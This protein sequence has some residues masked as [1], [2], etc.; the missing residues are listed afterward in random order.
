MISLLGA[1]NGLGLRGGCLGG[2]GT[3][4]TGLGGHGKTLLDDE[5]VTLAREKS[6]A[7]RVCSRNLREHKR[8]PEDRHVL[9]LPR[10]GPLYGGCDC[11][12]LTGHQTWTTG[13]LVAHMVGRLALS[14]EITTTNDHVDQSTR[15]RPQSFN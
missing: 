9:K 14:Q 15:D 10:L 13:N 6:P 11:K 1:A 8:P 7:S 5:L 3:L 12:N 4:D 2:R